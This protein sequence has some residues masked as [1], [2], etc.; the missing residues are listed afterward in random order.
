MVVLYLGLFLITIFR[1]NCN[2]LV[3]GLVRTH[4][5]YGCRVFYQYAGLSY[6][7]W[8]SAKNQKAWNQNT[9]NDSPAKIFPMALIYRN[10]NCKYRLCRCSFSATRYALCIIDN[11]RAWL[12]WVMRMIREGVKYEGAILWIIDH[13]NTFSL[14]TFPILC[15]DMKYLIVFYKRYF[16][17]DNV[18]MMNF[19]VPRSLTV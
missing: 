5:P 18:G 13:V 14:G 17:E 1:I 9:I 8:T 16:M 15:I 4:T 19:S 2:F 7:W 10:A 3:W 12:V 6:E 11:N